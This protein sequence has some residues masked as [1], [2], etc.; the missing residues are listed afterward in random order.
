MLGFASH[1]ISAINYSILLLQC[2]SD[3]RQYAN[4]ELWLC[5][6]ET[7]LK[8]AVIFWSLQDKHNPSELCSDEKFCV[9]Q[10]N[11]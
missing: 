10:H 11:S 2:K 4:E 3:H 5:Y 1:R 7:L 6:N 9:N 8:K